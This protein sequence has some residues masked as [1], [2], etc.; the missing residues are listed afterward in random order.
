MKQK[1]ALILL[2]FVLG[3]SMSACASGSV[4]SVTGSEEGK[5]ADEADEA[6]DDYAL[7]VPESVQNLS[8]EDDL[9]LAGELKDGVYI[10]NYFG[11]KLSVP[12]GGT[13]IRDNDDALS[14][15]EFLPLSKTYEDGWGGWSY[16]AEIAGVDGSITVFITALSDDEAGLTEKE[17]VEKHVKAYQEIDKLLGDDEDVDGDGTGSEEG[18]K[19]TTV[20]LAGEE[21]P[22]SV[23]IS[24]VDGN[25]Y[26]SACLYIPKG[27]FEYIIYL[28][29][30]DLKPEDLTKY[31]EKP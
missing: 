31:F 18:P 24:R 4:Q 7:E 23:D 10:N 19:N 22:A 9:L 21:H 27:D 5:E 3:I 25:D 11:Y 12:E 2:T 29:G 28:S 20:I 16:S 13:I 30:P 1:A 8:E 6:D 15:N 14:T 17:L 26:L